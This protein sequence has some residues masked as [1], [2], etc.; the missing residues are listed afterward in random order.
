[1][2]KLRLLSILSYFFQLTSYNLLNLSKQLELTK[3]ECVQLLIEANIYKLVSVN[4]DEERNLIAIRNS[5][6]R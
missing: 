4:I 6:I 1:M 3:D 2:K 5:K